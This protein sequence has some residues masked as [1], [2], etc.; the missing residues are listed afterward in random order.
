MRILGL[1][2]IFYLLWVISVEV[3]IVIVDAALRDSL[4]DTLREREGAASLGNSHETAPLAPEGPMNDGGEF[5]LDLGAEGEVCRD[6]TPAETYGEILLMELS[7]ISLI[8]SVYYA[9]QIRSRL[10]HELV[11][12]F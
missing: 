4:R 2:G 11:H 1:L 6:S 5:F 8:F 12:L 7:F 9:L 3:N 10:V